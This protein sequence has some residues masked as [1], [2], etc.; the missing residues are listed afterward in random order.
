VLE[1]ALTARRPLAEL[2]L[3]RAGPP[4]YDV[5]RFFLAR[6][7]EQLYR[8]IDA[9]CERIAAGGLL[10]ARRAAPAPTGL[11]AA[12]APR[13]PYMSCS[14][15][16]RT[17]GSACVRTCSSCSW[18]PDRM[19][20]D[21]V[22]LVARWGRL[23]AAPGSASTGKPGCLLDAEPT[24][25]PRHRPF[26][27]GCRRAARAGR[28]AGRPRGAQEAQALLD[29]GL[30][31]D[32]CCAAR[33]IGYRQALEFLQRCHAQSDAVS[34]DGLARRLSPGRPSASTLRAPCSACCGF[35]RMLR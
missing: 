7:R 32:S 9:R 20:P 25:C 34:A 13:C 35:H 21:L 14:E 19:P 8:R 22:D 1:V 23:S 4:D 16:R 5:R 27:R 26:Q 2:D 18:P 12:C 11:G 29:A 33:A 24:R 10:Q 6:P 3:D 17:G 31:A 15:G 28:R 30:P